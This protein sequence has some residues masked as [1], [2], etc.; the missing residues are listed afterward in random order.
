MKQRVS[1]YTPQGRFDFED[2]NEVV[3]REGI[4]VI[5]EVAAVTT[6][7]PE[8]AVLRVVSSLF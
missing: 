3:W 5:R 4:L 8:H 6:S 1:V 2:V 7:F